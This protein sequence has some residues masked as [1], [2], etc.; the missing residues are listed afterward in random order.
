V[1]EDDSH[2]T[3]T[4]TIAAEG[5]MS[6]NLLRAFA[7]WVPDASVDPGEGPVGEQRL[8]YSTTLHPNNSG[9][10]NQEVSRRCCVGRSADALSSAGQCQIAWA[11]SVNAAAT[12]SAGHA[13]F[14][15]S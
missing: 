6:G 15:S 5:V 7:S 8:F 4:F 12:R 1:P 3:L 11:S 10:I 9:V 13:S 14:P 2:A